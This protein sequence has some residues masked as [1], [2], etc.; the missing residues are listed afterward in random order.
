MSSPTYPGLSAA[1]VA[2]RVA[3]GDTNDFKA[4]VGRTY[5]QIVRDNLLNLFNIVLFSLLFLVILLRDYS[6]A[7]FAG[8]S[9]VSNSF[10]G[11]IQEISAK[12][13]L[14]SLAALAAKE[15]RVFRGGQLVTVPIE[16]IVKDDV[17][18][19]EP[20][21]RLVVDGRVLHSDALEMDESHLTGE[22]DAVLKDP[23][24]D[25]YSGSYCVAGTGVMVA[26]AV[27]RHSTI[28]KLSTIAKAYKNVQT[29]TQQKIAALVELSV[30]AMLILGRCCSF[31]DWSA[32]SLFWKTSRTRWSS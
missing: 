3:R 6:T 20:G 29:P 11:M 23:G 17:M 26:T 21:D 19:I 12:R 10:L 22:S 5:W 14:D 28:N 15:V 27:G 8:F 30:I 9:V 16:R 32:I 7:L 2:E 31:R 1:E 13:K 4:R 18:P 24:H 25:V